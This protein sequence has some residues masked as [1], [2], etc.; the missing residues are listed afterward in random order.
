MK[1]LAFSFFAI[2]IAIT[3]F[4][5]S[6]SF[7]IKAGINFPSQSLSGYSLYG[8]SSGQPITGF[9]VGGMVDV[10]FGNFSIQ[11]GLFYSTKGTEIQSHPNPYIG[12]GPSTY[13]V[14]T[15]TYNLKYIELPVNLI[16][17][18]PVSS[19]IRI[20]IGVGPYIGYGISANTNTAYAKIADSFDDSSS[21]GAHYKNPD[22]GVNFLGGIE[23]QK[24]FL[25]DVQYSLGLTNISGNNNEYPASDI[26]NRVFSI[27]VGYLFR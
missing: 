10:G 21:S 13:I 18:I 8:L 23:V 26:K 4:A 17:N 16:Y 20:P 14:P 7:G 19:A 22:I 24:K 3:S 9:N 15:A 6:V 25:I 11:P 1:E 27:S 2:F 5:Q 12:N